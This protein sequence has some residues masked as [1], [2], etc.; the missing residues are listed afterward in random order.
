MIDFPV[1]IPIE[2]KSREFDGKLLIAAYLLNA[3][4]RDVY[5]G[6]RMGILYETLYNRPGI[7]L[8]KSI[9][10]QQ[11]T[12]YKQLKAKGFILAL[13]HV[14]GGI[15]YRETKEI[16]QSYYPQDLLD[17]IDI[18]FVFGQQVKKDIALYC[19]PEHLKKI[20]VSGEPRFELLK[21]KFAPF[22]RNQVQA[23]QNLYG[24][25]ILIN[26][27]F[28]AG[29]S[30]T[31]KSSLREF[32]LAEP[33]YSDESKR[34]YMMKMDLLEK[35]VEHYVSAIK[36]LST[37]FAE[38][39][40]IV[41]PHPSES[42]IV[43]RTTFKDL[44][45]VFVVKEGNVAEWIIAAKG[46]IHY[47]CTTGMEAVLADK[48]VISYLPIKSEEILAW[49]PVE[50]SKVAADE[51]TLVS[52]VNEIILGTF[53]N[54]LSIELKSIWKNT[55]YNTDEDSAAIICYS[56]ANINH[57]EPQYSSYYRFKLILARL[58]S[59]AKAGKKSLVRS[60]HTILPNNRTEYLNKDLQ[61]ASISIIEVRNKLATIKEIMKYTGQEKVRKVGYGVIKIYRK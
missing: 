58:F 49:L 7:V 48:P 2:T 1:Y 56:L 60:F 12:Y 3:G 19:A 28:S 36:T 51:E 41:R 50:L 35:V 6:T 57:P 44:K 55:L 25:F 22:F 52:L 4:F 42:E 37:R 5:L 45:N 18:N 38:V 9:S 23:L 10:R 43:Y 53:S 31:G 11:E 20:V 59:Y 34:L 54:P 32:I 17:Y 33:T 14:E 40:F 16:M 27:N 30:V 24:D 61:I 29:N 46:I 39:N 15:H 13:L 26:T 47:D 21:P 8:F